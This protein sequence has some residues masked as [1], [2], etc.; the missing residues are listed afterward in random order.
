[1]SL[2]PVLWILAQSTKIAP[3]RQSTPAKILT[4]RKPTSQLERIAPATGPLSR[5]AMEETAK[6]SPVRIPMSWIGDIC[7]TS[8]G[9]KEAYAPEKKPKRTAKTITAALLAAGIQSA[10]MR[11]PVPVLTNT[12]TLNR[13]ILSAIRPAESRPKRLQLD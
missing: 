9:P 2:K 1:M 5:P 7:A 10:R 13:P 12:K 8:A 11:T 4:P 3:A 6:N